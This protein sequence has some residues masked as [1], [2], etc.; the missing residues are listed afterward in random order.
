MQQNPTCSSCG[1]PRVHRSHRRGPVERIA[2]LCG[3]SMVRCHGCN[4]RFVRFGKTL[5]RADHFR[6]VWRRLAVVLGVLVG[7]TLVLGLI[8]WLGGQSPPPDQEGLGTPP[9]APSGCFIA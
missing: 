5:S 1:S 2:V 3:G 6:K 8:L 7:A 9:P 4:V